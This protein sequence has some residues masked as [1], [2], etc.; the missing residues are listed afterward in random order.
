MRFHE[1][2]RWVHHGGG[3]NVHS[4]PA[5]PDAVYYRSMIENPISLAMLG[6]KNRV[7]GMGVAKP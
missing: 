1:Q 3:T 5:K 2:L 4:G 7:R 6:A